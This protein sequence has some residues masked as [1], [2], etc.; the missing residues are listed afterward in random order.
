M[1][2]CG[3]WYP[4]IQRLTTLSVNLELVECLAMNGLPI[5][6]ECLAAHPFGVSGYLM[7][8]V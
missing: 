2:R 5:P 3:E 8:T 6:S 1:T 7:L 4:P